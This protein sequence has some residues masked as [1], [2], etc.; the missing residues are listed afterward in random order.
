L[1]KVADKRGKTLS[2]LVTSI[3][4]QSS[5]IRLFILKFYKDELAQ[6]QAMFEQRKISVQGRKKR[7]ASI[8]GR[9]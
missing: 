3:A 7:R 9:A 5:S 4:N 2:E 6:Q 1:L 8:L